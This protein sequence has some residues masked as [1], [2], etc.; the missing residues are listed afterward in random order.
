M[1]QRKKDVQHTV[2]CCLISVESSGFCSVGVLLL[3]GTVGRDE[4]EANE[5]EMK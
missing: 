2:V 3:T 4:Q 1:G 5:A